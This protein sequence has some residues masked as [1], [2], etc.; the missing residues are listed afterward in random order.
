V[1]LQ[2]DKAD[3][4]TLEPLYFKLTHGFWPAD[5]PTHLVPCQ[6]ICSLKE[7]TET[8]DLHRATW[9]VLDLQPLLW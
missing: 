9:E 5:Y 2:H 6:G 7:K 4:C 8:K 3:F 1:L